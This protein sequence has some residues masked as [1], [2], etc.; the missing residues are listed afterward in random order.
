MIDRGE[1]AFVQTTVSI[2][3]NGIDPV[4]GADLVVEAVDKPGPYQSMD[5]AMGPGA[6]Q[7]DG[8]VSSAINGQGDPSDV[9]I[10]LAKSD[11]FHVTC[12]PETLTGSQAFFDNFRNESPLTSVATLDPPIAA[13]NAAGHPIQEIE[14]DKWRIR[15]YDADNVMTRSFFMG[16]HF[17]DTLFD[18]PFAQH[19]NNAS[20][21]MMPKATADISGGKVLHVTFEVDAH[22]NGRRWC[23]LFIG[24][25]GDTL[26]HAAPGKLE[27]WEMPTVKGNLLYWEIAAAQH[28]IQLITPNP[29]PGASVVHSFTGLFQPASNDDL[30]SMSRYYE[31]QNWSRGMPGWPE[32][33]PFANG[34]V[35]NLDKRSRFDLYLSQTHYRIIE[36]ETNGTQRLYR[37]RDFPAGVT[38]PFSKLQVYFVHE[39]YHT[40]NDRPENV[41]SGP[42]CAYWYD[43][44][45]YSDERHW[46]NMGFEVLELVP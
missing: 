25:A 21:V 36:T 33:I 28:D 44:R 39:L 1:N 41:G 9:P 24:E 3:W 45:P 14:N 17:M 2:Q 18:G 8:S 15:T 19:N 11:S 20:L 38:L 13:I 30:G 23:D 7:M 31:V 46:D 22:F 29:T 32:G 4:N 34:L 37:D 40:G 26:L 5:G 27:N 6:M 12:Q 10:V 16:N 43:Y 35:Q 42:D